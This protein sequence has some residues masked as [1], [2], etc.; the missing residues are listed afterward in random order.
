MLRLILSSEFFI[1]QRAF[2][3]EEEEEEERATPSLHLLGEG[4]SSNFSR[5]L[6]LLPSCERVTGSV[7]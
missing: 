7:V 1:S 3:K 4:F 2:P 5:G 6:L